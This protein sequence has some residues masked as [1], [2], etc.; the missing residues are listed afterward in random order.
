MIYVHINTYLNDITKLYSNNIYGYERTI[1]YLSLV[2]D[3]NAYK[4]QLNLN[5]TYFNY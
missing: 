1:K 3:L 5:F 4:L 2:C